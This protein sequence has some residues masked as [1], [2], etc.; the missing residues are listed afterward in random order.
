[1]KAF[2]FWQRIGRLAAA[3]AACSIMAVAP[4]GAAADLKDQV[5]LTLSDRVRGEFVDWFQPPADKAPAGVQ[6]YDFLANQLR[7]GFK[8]SAPHTLLTVEVQ[9]TQFVNLP[10]DASLADRRLPQGNLGPGALYYFNT[11][12]RDQ[13]EV[14]LKQ[15]HISVNGLPGWNEVSGTFGRFDYNDGME[16]VPTDPSLTWLKRARISERLVGPFTYTHVTRSFDGARVA[17][18]NS[19]FNVTAMGTRP[20]NGGFEVSANRELEIWL[21]GL[22]VTMK[23]IENLAPIDARLF[24]LFY[25]DERNHIALP[26]AFMVDNRSTVPAQ[27]TVRKQDTGHLN[28]HTWG[29][30]VVTVVDAGPGKADGL[31][32]G[33]LQAGDW[34]QLHHFAW[35]F[36]AEAGYQ[37]P[38]VFAAP[39]LRVGYDRG[40][41][42]TDPND[43]DHKTFFQ[44]LPTARLYAQMPF[45]NLMNSEDLFGQLMVKPHAKVTVR[46]DYH[47]LRLSSSKDLWYAGGG[48]TNNQIFGFTGI[49]AHDQKDL[50]HVVDISFTVSIFKQLSAYAYYG[51]A[52]GEGVVKGTFPGG[53][54]ANYGY[55]E[56]TYRY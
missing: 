20:T 53:D 11:H 21:A 14:F 54:T 6:R 28:I 43:K 47:W 23:K 13:G 24:Y 55:L 40:S 38:K 42:D 4:R 37:F 17:Y 32:W 22:A 45:F 35:A 51:R 33:A 8:V 15:A 30:H 1:M 41:G 29:G 52:F 31:L 16:T 36:A 9:D 50:A 27:D 26:S 25:R 18:D 39:W 34:G 49:A 7:V 19:T 12:R 2:P 46:T 10:N 56:L 5:T 48:A 3:V 44:I